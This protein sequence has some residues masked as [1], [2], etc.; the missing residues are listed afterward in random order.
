MGPTAL[1]ISSDRVLLHVL[2]VRSPL[3]H[4]FETVQ[5]FNLA[6]VYNDRLGHCDGELL[7]LRHL[8]PA[9]LTGQTLM[10]IVTN[11][12]GLLISRI[13]LGVTGSS[14]SLSRDFAG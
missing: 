9:R 6:S 14:P 7:R 10:G 3:K 1:T 2:R 11:Y 5:A 8:L 4:A 13:F 12:H